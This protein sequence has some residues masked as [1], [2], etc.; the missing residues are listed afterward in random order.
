MH[1]CGW[2][3]MALSETHAP[4]SST[5]RMG[6][7]LILQSGGEAPEHAGVAFVI[8][9][10]WVR[11]MLDFYPLNSRCA[12]VTLRVTGGVLTIIVVYFPY[13]DSS[14]AQNV[15]RRRDAFAN[16]AEFALQQQRQGP[17]IMLGDFNTSVRVRAADESPFVGPHMYAPPSR[18][19]ANHNPPGPDSNHA[20]LVDL[21]RSADLVVRNTFLQK[22][23]MA[24]VTYVAPAGRLAEPLDYTTCREL[25]HTL[26]SKTYASKVTDVRS[27]RDLRIGPSGHYPQE[28]MCMLPV[29]LRQ[30]RR[31]VPRIPR[32]LWRDEGQVSIMQAHLVEFLQPRVHA[33][34]P[35]PLHSPL[36]LREP[37]SP[38]PGL[39][40]D[41]YMDGS[42]EPAR[43]RFQPAGW[44]F[45]VV[46][47]EPVQLGFP[48]TTLY[49]DGSTTFY[50]IYAR[51]G[52]VITDQTDR[53]FLGARHMS[54]NTGE[55]TAFA[56]A[57]FWLMFDLPFDYRYAA[58]VFRFDSFLSGN[59]SS[60]DWEVRDSSPNAAL[61]RTSHALWMGL[62]PDQTR[63]FGRWVRGHSDEPGN[64]YVDH[65]AERGAH[66]WNCPFR[67]T[68]SFAEIAPVLEVQVEARR[69]EG[70]EIMNS[71]LATGVEDLYGTIRNAAAHAIKQ[72]AMPKAPQHRPY[73]SLPCLHLI[74]ERNTAAAAG[75]IDRST[76]LTKQ[77]KRECGK[78]K[79]ASLVEM[80][81]TWAD[82]KRDW[83]GLPRMK[84]FQPTQTRMLNPQG[85]VVPTSE[86]PQVLANHY[87]D[88][89]WSVADLPPLPARPP[90]YPSA[91][92]PTN[93]FEPHE[94]RVVGR[95]LKR[96]RACGTDDIS[97]EMLLLLLATPEGFTLILSLMNTCWRDCRV[98]CMF[99]VGRIAAL[100]KQKGDCGLPQNY[101]P[102]SLLQTLYKMFTRL[103]EIRLRTSLTARI[104]KWQHGFLKGRSVDTAIFAL[105]R[106]IEIAGG[107]RDYPLY[108]LLLDW[109]KAYDRVHHDRMLDALR[110]IGVPD[111]YIAILRVLYTDMR[112]FVA[113]G[114]D[115]STEEPQRT[116]LRQG[117]PLSCFLFILLLT[118]II[119]DAEEAWTAAAAARGLRG[120][121]RTVRAFG[122]PLFKYADDTNSLNVCWRT[123]ELVLQAIETE[124]RI[125]GLRLNISKTFVL[126][127]GAAGRLAPPQIHSI[128][129][130]Q[131]AIA[132]EERT[133][134]F[135]LGAAVSSSRT[136]RQRTAIMLKKMEQFRAIWRS[137]LSN[138]KKMLK[139]ESLILN[140]VSWG[141]HL[142]TLYTADLDHLDYMHA[143]GLR[144]IAKI[145]AAFVSHVSNA[146]VFK[147][148]KATPL[149]VQIRRRQYALLG[150]ILRIP[151][152]QDPNR[153]ACFN[154]DLTCTRR[155]PA[156]A[157]RRQGRPNLAWPD[158]LIRDLEVSAGW[159]RAELIT[160][161]SNRAQWYAATQKA[162]RLGR[163]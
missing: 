134:G 14:D 114:A 39:R 137:N 121:D 54:N 94:L 26:V 75:D 23:Q 67:R 74:D 80:V 71:D 113:C 86:K 109:E 79:L 126:L 32:C 162:A 125:Y 107:L 5:F 55:L 96:N 131:I 115:K 141:L 16:A 105:L 130:T 57:E 63:V 98:P 156:G 93:A 136:V 69:A 138:Q 61:A 9:A 68:R 145:P 155:L 129:G 65:W 43:R 77:L 76:A 153:L 104:S 38:L 88:H 110:R 85:R 46:C 64:E 106:S 12:A 81:D 8:H 21:C 1:K 6:E 101:R 41:I 49:T 151:D 148:L 147:R 29:V 127:F 44:A 7:Y 2:M 163:P 119:A 97:N 45:A 118:V 24:K 103:I 158:T 10:D 15:R 59:Q 135:R 132:N 92:M 117:D 73:I 100:Y 47:S 51:W 27:R 50:V 56:E 144:R 128:T 112:F 95:S 66:G 58:V 120:V 123:L 84:P 102:I 161:A 159:Q 18:A 150:H 4:G 22:R 36:N 108:V 70:T 31:R 48:I 53:Q 33:L 90:L 142:L 146:A 160:R 3:L 28:V 116:G 78:A 124:A 19:G 83:G 139:Y 11:N 60:G 157:R 149:S 37:P 30:R 34:M 17:I 89:Q 87:R 82:P 133:L 152:P 140:Q 40:F 52:P 72:I 111:T 154:P 122:L 62:R 99:M 13:E 42:W 91:D 35:G 143:R 20:M 25:D